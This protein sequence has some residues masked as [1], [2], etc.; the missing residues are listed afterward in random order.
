MDCKERRRVRGS[1]PECLG[2]DTA[3]RTLSS[4]EDDHVPYLGA[5]AGTDNTDLRGREGIDQTA[6][7]LVAEERANDGDNSAHSLTRQP[8]EAPGRG[9]RVPI[10][11]ETTTPIVGAGP[12]R[13]EAPDQAPTPSQWPR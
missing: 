7:V 12:T 1:I 11:Q 5:V 3:E 6:L 4:P 9:I 2:P 13:R 10:S 8:E